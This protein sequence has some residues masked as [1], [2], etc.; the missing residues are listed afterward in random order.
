MRARRFDVAEPPKGFAAGLFD[1]HSAHRKL[2]GTRGDVGLNLVVPFVRE[3][4]SAIGNVSEQA[5]KAAHGGFAGARQAGRRWLCM[6]SSSISAYTV[7]RDASAR[8]W[9]RPAAV[10]L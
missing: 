9:A 7:Q 4:V 5:A 3:E 6:I 1:R 2:F 8:S 10:S